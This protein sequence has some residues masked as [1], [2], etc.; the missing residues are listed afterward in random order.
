MMVM[1]LLLH[2]GQLRFHGSLALHRLQQLLAGKLIPRGSHDGGILI[3]LP[4]HSYR[5]IQFFLGNKICTGEY[6]RTG[7]FYLI[8]VELTKV[9][10]IYLHLGSIHYRHSKAQ[11]N[12]ITGN[13]LRGSDHIG[14][15]THTGRLD[16][17][18][19]GMIFL[20]YLM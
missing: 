17:N 9:L 20:N 14:K 16:Q 1:M 15:L 8:I 4:E 19:V 7:S 12:I 2:T 11:R 3:M 5:S 10:H 13:L 6:H 18:A